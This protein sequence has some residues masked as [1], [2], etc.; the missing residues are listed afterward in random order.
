MVT[1]EL[2]MVR[3]NI[4]WL[5][6]YPKS[7]N[8]WLRIVLGHL[9][10]KEKSTIVDINQLPLLRDG[11]ASG[12]DLFDEEVGVPAADLDTDTIDRLRPRVYETLSREA[13]RQM[14]IKAHD[15]YLPTP[16]GEPMFPRSATWGVIHV[17]RNPRDV[18]VSYADHTAV[19]LDRAIEELGNPQNCWCGKRHRLHEQLR[20]QLSDW[21]GHADSWLNSPLPRLTIRYEDML[22]SPEKTFAEVAAFCG[23][24]ATALDVALAVEASRFERLQEMEATSRFRE[25]PRRGGRF[26]RRGVAGGWKDVLTMEQASRIVER[27]GSMMQRFGYL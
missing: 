10:N 11:I 25:S 17:V 27:H 12:R 14:F 1:P 18:A 6:S 2:S 23:L 15:A 4:V 20:Q 3:G 26:F 16:G 5:A 9:M 19:S 22:A 8:T 13:N 24:A 7:G 21:S